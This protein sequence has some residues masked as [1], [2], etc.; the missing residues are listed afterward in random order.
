MVVRNLGGV[1]I[2]ERMDVLG[3]VEQKSKRKPMM[4]P[5]RYLM[6]LWPNRAI[7]AR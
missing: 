6:N 3:R 5:I 2:V 4:K 1:G 7:K